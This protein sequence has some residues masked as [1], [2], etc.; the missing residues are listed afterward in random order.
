MDTTPRSTPSAPTRGRRPRRLAATVGALAL[1]VA[2]PLAAGAAT[3][4]TPADPPPPAPPQH[5]QGGHDL[6]KDDLDAWLDGVVGSALP[7]TGIPGAAVSVVADGEVLTS[8][9]YGLAD[10]GT[11]SG[12]ARP[13]DPDDTLF[14]VGSVSKV[15]SATAVMQLVEE[16]RLDLDADVQQYLD[17]DLDTPKG[18]VTLRHLLTHTSGFEEVIT[19]LIGLPGSERALGDVM[20]EDPP[21]Q[22]FVPGTTPA[23]SNYGASL[24]GYVAE[25]VAGKPF[26]DL[27]QEEVLDR[28]GMTSSS[29][30]Q[31]LPA[32]LDARLAE[33]YPDDS[34][35]AYPTEVVNAAPA[36]A[37]SATASDMARFMLGHLGDLPADQALLDPATLD[38][39]HRPALDADQLGTLAAGQRMDLAFFD[40]S[41]PGVPAFGHDGDTNV[42]HTAMRMFPESDA[43]IF[44]T[45][46]GYGRDA[47]DTLELRTTVLQGFADR[48]L[49]ADDGTSGSAAA[50]TGD[51]A[52]AAALAGTWLSSRSPFSNP[53]ALL[54]L[55][56]QTEIVPRADGTIAVTPKPLGVTTGVYEKAGDDLWREVGGDAVLATRA[57]SDGGPVDA[58]S[59]GAS[60]TLLRAEPW[61]VASVA[62]PLLLASVAVLLVSVIVWP[63][64][65][66]A[67]FGRRRAARADAEVPAAPRP[68]RSRPHLLS[69]I[70]QAVTLVALLGW[71]AAAVQALSL[72]DVPAGALRTLQG[73]QVLGALAVIP[74]ALA[75]WQAV[76]T[77]RGAWIVAGRI[78][79][80]LALVA[81][82]A[83]A[84]GFRL[85]AP[86][87]S[88]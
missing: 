62:M 10:T 2:L 38:E 13:V 85:L 28:A 48:Y 33:G 45:F 30:A 57:S 72:V 49:R 80:L 51:P 6:T 47:V 64:T 69:R 15:V 83:F 3:P 5:Q 7:T 17:F 9:G 75:A 73:L 40:D 32:D 12:T 31:P 87:V 81:V 46:N 36:G 61:Q 25:R 66:I 88:Y 19:G 43:G 76:R 14:R 18:A 21:E 70:G 56:G 1:A 8:R 60:F 39:M 74:A 16:G 84:V 34:Q 26:V 65:A 41:A 78:L 23:Y 22:V 24:A 37:L 27:V 35:P 77:R 20:K 58:I 79:V 11:E 63:A 86:S 54:N 67:G 71:T 59:W 29:F 44:V 4:A 55:S 52:A 50:P 68:R 42:F 53:G 82:A